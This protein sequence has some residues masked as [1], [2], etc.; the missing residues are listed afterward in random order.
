MEIKVSSIPDTGTAISC[1]SFV[2]SSEPPYIGIIMRPEPGTW[3]E[4]MDQDFMFLIHGGSEKKATIKYRI[5]VGDSSI[6]FIPSD[7]PGFRELFG[8]LTD[9]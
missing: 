3:E 1:K 7:D 8:E 5:E 9:G 2:A 4:L 6:F